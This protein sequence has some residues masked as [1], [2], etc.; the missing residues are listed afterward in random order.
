[1]PRLKQ[2]VGALGRDLQVLAVEI[3][4]DRETAEKFIAENSLDFVFAY[5][6]RAFVK[7]YFNTAGYPNSFM[8]DRSGVI[9]EHK[10]GFKMGQE[11]GMMQTL[12]ALLEE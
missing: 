8:I 1:M 12:Q 3:N 4:N 6:D 9:R 2:V 7:K 10:M 5:A 11:V